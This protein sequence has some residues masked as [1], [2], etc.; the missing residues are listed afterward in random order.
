M[1]EDRKSQRSLNDDNNN[2]D[3]GMG[4]NLFMHLQTL[5]MIQDHNNDN[6]SNDDSQLYEGGDQK[7]PEVEDDNFTPIEDSPTHKKR[8]RN[9]LKAI[10]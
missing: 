3:D 1:D 2:D 8:S 9:V 4:R 7:D 6:I 10:V 5:K